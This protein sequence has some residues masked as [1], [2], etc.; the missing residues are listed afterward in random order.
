LTAHQLFDVRLSKGRILNRRFFASTA[1]AIPPTRALLPVAGRPRQINSL[2]LPGQVGAALGLNVVTSSQFA[3]GAKGDGRTNDAPAFAAA[4][5]AGNM[6]VPAGQYLLATSLTVD[7]SMIFG[8]EAVVIV[9]FGVTVTFSG[10]IDAQ[11]EHI[12]DVRAGSHIIFK[13][14]NAV[15]YAEWFGARGDGATDDSVAIN[16]AIASVPTNTN[17]VV[18][19]GG[20]VQLLAKSY[21]HTAPIILNKSNCALVGMGPDITYLV[22]PPNSTNDGL[23]VGGSSINNPYLADFTI[24]SGSSL[25]GGSASTGRGLVLEHLFLLRIR[26]V[27]VYRFGT[28]IYCTDVTTGL[29]ENCFVINQNSSAPNVYGIHYDGTTSVQSVSLRSC[30]MLLSGHTGAGFSYGFKADGPHL[31]DIWV[32]FCESNLNSFGYYLELSSA[33]KLGQATDIQFVRCNADQN[34]ISGIVVTGA[35]TGAAVNI[36]GG[37]FSGETPIQVNISNSFGVQLRGAQVLATLANT[38]SG[39][40]GLTNCQQ[41]QIVENQITNQYTGISLVNSPGNIIVGNAIYMMSGTTAIGGKGI[42]V[43]AGSVRCAISNNLIN[44]GVLNGYSI[45]VNLD[46]N[47]DKC[48]VIGNIYGL[49]GVTTGQINEPGNVNSVLVGVTT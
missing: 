47:T 5:A 25:A 33:T 1:L 39:G 45:G 13:Q 44:A 26:N 27:N 43:G 38:G 18:G 2:D 14:S 16:A 46:T 21:Y 4:N 20:R 49:P 40:I 7:T 15:L 24:I 12:F 10:T 34:S 48:N 29:I 37:W 3:G 30:H 8:P 35:P 31:N 11:P 17:Y 22:S 42:Q 23:I 32:E 19:S 36:N 41:C 6:Y 9:P 28:G